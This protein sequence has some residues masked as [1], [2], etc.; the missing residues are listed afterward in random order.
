MHNKKSILTK[1]LIIFTLILTFTGCGSVRK[2]DDYRI[3][4]HFTFRDATYSREAR[5]RGIKNYPSKKDYKRIKY[6]AKRME[7]IRKIVGKP[8]YVNSWYRSPN[9]NRVVGGSH[10]SAHRDGL[11]VDFRIN[12]DIR[13]AF[14]KIRRSGYSFD[15]MILYPRRNY[16]HIGFR[17]KK[18]RERKQI[19]YK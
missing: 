10:S 13:Y 18:R 7:K 5:K 2:R 6:T 11:A 4:K 14:N 8:L 17:Y 15:Q 9:L 19:F 1:F 3:S 12:G 16:I